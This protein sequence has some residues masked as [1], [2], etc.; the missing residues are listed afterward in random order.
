MN[1]R[2]KLAANKFVVT[3]ELDPPKTLNLERILTEVNSTNFRKL[4]DA[5]NVTDC[6][7]AKLRMSPIALSHIIQERI[8]LEAIFHITCR[9]RNLLGLQAELLGASALGVKNILALTGD[10]PEMGDYTRAT[11]VFDV[12]SIGLVKMVN[13]LN[14]GYEYSGNELKDKT[15][16]FIGIAVNPTAQDLKKEIA[17]FEEKLSAGTNFVQTQP[18]YDIGLLERFLKLTA[19][20]NIPKIIGIMPLKSYKMVEYL[21]KNLPGIFVP[22]EVK[23]R[24]RGKDVEE[25]VKISRELISKIR[26]F[27]EVTG[28]HIF[29]LRDMDLVCR[30][31]S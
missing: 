23:E 6:P 30:L 13:K 22:P 3:V 1:L 26:K 7:L 31:L 11:G 27:K 20:I 19:H 5:V 4:V 17:R 8:G 15:D 29:P 28:I 18:I 12:D 24:M 14:N 21:N 9:D 25:G 10:L 16:F 2:E